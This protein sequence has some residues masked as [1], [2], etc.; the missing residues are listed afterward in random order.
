MQMTQIEYKIIEKIY[1]ASLKFLEPLD[2]DAAFSTIVD[3]A[4]RLVDGDYGSVLLE[5]NYELV[6]VYASSEIAFKTQIRKNG[7]T[8]RCFK[9][10]KPVLDTIKGMQEAHP[11]LKEAGIRSTIFIPLKSKGRSIGVMTVNSKKNR[12]FSLYEMH[13]LQLF[14]SMAS[15]AIRKT[16]LYDETK[17][18]LETRDMFISMASHELRTPLTTINGY[19]QLLQTKTGGK[20]EISNIWMEELGKELERLTLLVKELLEI[21]RIKSGNLQYNFKE[22][23]INEI[24]NRAV[25]TVEFGYPN[26]KIIIYNKTSSEDTVIGDYDKLLQAISNILENAAKYS[27]NSSQIRMSITKKT[28][29][30]KIVVRDK[31][32][33]IPENELPNI[34]K[35]YSQGKNHNREGLG[36]GLFLAKNIVDKHLGTIKIA[37]AE[38][39]GTVVVLTLPRVRLVAV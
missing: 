27:G 15:L 29:Q 5:H 6:R 19:F 3:E 23:N 25:K 13:I 10:G 21:N 7:N 28:N 20:K 8:Y 32:I 22:S 33:G 24:V 1:K 9:T 16:Q 11:E 2:T 4:V 14:G 39:K 38:N 18:A 12:Q 37:S 26:K 35:G 36:L 17:R 31:G 34:F 30:L